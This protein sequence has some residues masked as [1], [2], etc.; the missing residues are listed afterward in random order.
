MMLKEKSNPWLRLKYLY[1]LPLATVAV[2]VF[3]RPEI[4]ATVEEISAV[5]VN[6]LAS[7][8]EAKVGEN[9]N[10]MIPLKVGRSSLSQKHLLSIKDTTIVSPKKAGDKVT[11]ELSAKENSLKEGKEEIIVTSYAKGK[12]AKVKGSYNKS[13]NVKKVGNVNIYGFSEGEQPLF[14]V[15]GK[16]VLQDDFSTI[17]PDRIESI[18]VLKSEAAT[19]VY[20][21]KGKKGVVLVTLL[22]DEKY[23]QQKKNTMAKTEGLEV[24][25]EKEVEGISDNSVQMT[26]NSSGVEWITVNGIVKDIKGKALNGASVIVKGTPTGTIT[27]N[28]GH[29]SLKVPKDSMLKIIYMGMASVEVEAV[30]ELQVVLKEEK[31]K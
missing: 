31:K 16:E 27:D 30:S 22:S 7:I 12:V 28:E 15:D 2:A 21:E 25:G 13:Q 14:V 18:S 8:G 20:G 10:A 9:V 1:I 6:D 24:H 4:S 19:R 23:E 26:S 5:K 29:F 11:T 17:P 3:A